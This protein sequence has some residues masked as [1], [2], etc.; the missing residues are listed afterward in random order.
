MLV[1]M[2]GRRGGL[3]L[4]VEWL[5]SGKASAAEVAARGWE[6]GKRRRPLPRPPIPTRGRAAVS[7]ADEGT[8]G[9][10]CG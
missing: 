5:G 4:G 6:G 2:P 3:R 8:R 9:G 1:G 7:S 10:E